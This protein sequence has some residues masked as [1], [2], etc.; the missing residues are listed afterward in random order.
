MTSQAIQLKQLSSM[1]NIGK[2]L[3]QR[4]RAKGIITSGTLL[5][6]VL[7]WES[8]F[9]PWLQQEFGATTEE[10]KVCYDGLTGWSEQY[11]VGGVDE[12]IESILGK[13]PCVLAGIT[14]ELSDRLV[15]VG[16]PSAI[17]I[18]GMYLSQSD[19]FETWFT[20]YEDGNVNTC[21]NE[22]DDIFHDA[23]VRASTSPNIMC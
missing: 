21:V 4:L 22:L 15:K 13:P 3:V 2:E 17:H 23:C 7:L 20:D 18:L 5:G 1:P 19:V 11:L 8:E 9:E 12:K 14:S 6:Y 16:Y 10:S